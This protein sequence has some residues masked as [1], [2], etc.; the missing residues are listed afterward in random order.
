MKSI[1]YGVTAVSCILIVAA[2]I[3]SFSLILA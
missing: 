3:Y 1:G 2:Y